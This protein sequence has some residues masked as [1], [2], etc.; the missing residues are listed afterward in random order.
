MGF[1]FGVSLQTVWPWASY[2]I[3]L[4]LDF[5]IYKMGIM[6]SLCRWDEIMSPVVDPQEVLLINQPL[7]LLRVTNVGPLKM[8]LIGTNKPIRSFNSYWSDA[9]C[10]LGLG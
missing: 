9:Y 2:F 7:L 8:D 1:N 10:V 5:L 3:T 4:R 6:E